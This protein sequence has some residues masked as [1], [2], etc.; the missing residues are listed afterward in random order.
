MTQNT[1]CKKNTFFTALY[2]NRIIVSKGNTTPVNLP[3]LVG[4]VLLLFIPWLTVTGVVV[5]L[6]LGFRLSIEKNAA[7]FDGSFEAMVKRTA[8]DVKNAV[9]SI[10]QETAEDHA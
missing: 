2:R 5:A 6:A 10:G 7:E 8:E 3:I 1:N 9:A 4:I